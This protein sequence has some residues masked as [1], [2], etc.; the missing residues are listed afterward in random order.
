MTAYSSDAAFHR[1]QMAY[2][3]AMPPEA[4]EADLDVECGHEWEREVTNILG[5]SEDVTDICAFTGMVTVQIDGDLMYWECPVCGYSHEQPV[6]EVDLPER[7][8]Y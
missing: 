6:P 2:D 7:E 3:N 5:C 4:E 8:D 1:A